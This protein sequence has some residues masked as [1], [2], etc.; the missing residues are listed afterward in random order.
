MLEGKTFQA[1][2]VDYSVN[3]YGLIVREKSSIPINKIVDLQLNPPFIDTVGIVTWKKQIGNYLR[4]GIKTPWRIRGFLKDFWFS[5]ILIGLQRSRKT[6]LLKVKKG[7]IEKNVYMQNGDI[8]FA[9]S[10]QEDDQLNTMLLKE[11]MLSTQQ[12]NEAQGI[13]KKTRKRQEEILRELG[14]LKPHELIQAVKH[15]IESIICSLF[16]LTD[17]EFEFNEGPLPSHGEITLSLS[18]ANIIY[19]GIK[20]ITDTEYIRKMCPHSD[21]VLCF[22]SYP[23]DLFQD[24][25]LNEG[26]KAL[27]SYIDG[28]STLEDILYNSQLDESEILKTIFALLSTRIIDIR[29]AEQTY[30]H[31]SSAD[32]HNDHEIQST[33]EMIEKIE[34]IFNEYKNLTHYE[35]L[36]IPKFTNA[37]EI[38]KAYY[39]Q[40]KEFHPDRHFR[41][42]DDI[43]DK[44]Q[45]IFSYINEAY[46]TL[47]NSK[48]KEEYDR[49][50]VL[51]EPANLSP[52]ERARKKFEEGR[53]AF[54]NNNLLKA[55]R[56]FRY[57][58]YAD[59][60]T[61]KYHYYYAKSL[62]K[63]EKYKEAEQT[64]RHAIK[65]EPS[66]PDY[67]L[68]AGNIYHALGLMNKAKNSFE[69][70]LKL[71]PS[72]KKARE[73]IQAL[74]SE[75][76]KPFSK[77][78]YRQ[79]RK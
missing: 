45:L 66:N 62:F 36:D 49:S 53:L 24:L 57:A 60:Q 41:L 58:V 14:Y 51:K 7:A 54:W 48:S 40:A 69:K 47:I 15:H 11:E 52:Q 59:N 20:S 18:T 70:V 50:L 44:L 17:G 19:K 72:N 46:T 34:K 38:K 2:I 61:G 9:A 21:A 33:K 26:D 32:I 30:P 55:E 12:Y 35:I 77:I 28:K 10:N 43:K 5:D 27:L 25:D 73:L 4:V 37:E 31:I 71:Q 67:L 1:N 79:K 3:G 76:K 8:I 56:F 75:N 13:F 6:G 78:F 63:L 42:P 23:L 22:S 68:E 16:K 64:I 65:L 29:D 74:K 39:K